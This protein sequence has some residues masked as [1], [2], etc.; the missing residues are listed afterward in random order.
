MII[1]FGE[2]MCKKSLKI[3]SFLPFSSDVISNFGAVFGKVQCRSTLY[4]QIR[5]RYQYLREVQK[6]GICDVPFGK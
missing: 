2:E 6:D 5:I 1:L 4:Y 3:W